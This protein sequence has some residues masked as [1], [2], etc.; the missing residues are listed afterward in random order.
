M[1]DGTT[2]ILSHLLTFHLEVGGEKKKKSVFCPQPGSTALV[3][4]PKNSKLLPQLTL[5]REVHCRLRQS[6]HIYRYTNVSMDELTD[7]LAR[8]ASVSLSSQSRWHAASS[9]LCL[10]IIGSLCH[11][12]GWHF[13]NAA[14]LQ[15]IRAPICSIAKTY[16]TENPHGDR[17][18]TANLRC[19]LPLC[20]ATDCTCEPRIRASQ[21][22]YGRGT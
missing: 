13:R 12:G 11:H 2:V 21:L 15:L 19:K 10:P 20:R 4:G 5:E 22:L 1:V 8:Q 18:T 17:L 16:V 14:R 3:C 6:R 9:S 7:E